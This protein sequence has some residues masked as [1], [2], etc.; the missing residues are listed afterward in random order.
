[1]FISLEGGE[2]SGK[3]TISTLLAE[4]L[5]NEG[6]DVVLTREPGGVEIAEKIRGLIFD[7]H[8]TEKTEVLLFAAAR[9]EHLENVIKPAINAGKIVIC[10]RY[11]DS[12]VVYQGIARDQGA[13]SVR[14]LNY[15]ATDTYL[16]DM[17]ILFDIKPEIALKRIDS[18]LREVNRFDQE[19][20]DF[21]QKIYDA[22]QNLA[23]IDERI[24]SINAD[25]SIENV[26][27]EVYSLI[28]ENRIG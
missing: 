18:N 4:K 11:I 5:K 19:K 9:V 28:K 2:G 6:H 12:S 26:L 3:T 10:D 16:P 7:Y 25:Q 22:Y 1:M 15:W 21:H 24:I 14:D 23:S 27:E 13:K 8:I 20:L 17:T